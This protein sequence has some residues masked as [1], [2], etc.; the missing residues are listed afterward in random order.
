VFE[1]EAPREEPVLDGRGKTSPN[2]SLA[3]EERRRAVVEDLSTGAPEEDGSSEKRRWG[4]AGDEALGV[5]GDI[6][7]LFKGSMRLKVSEVLVVVH[8]VFRRPILRK[9]IPLIFRIASKFSVVG[10]LIFHSPQHE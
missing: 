8:V 5:I 4:D 3:T 1:S 10:S 2:G 9:E 7:G 6:L